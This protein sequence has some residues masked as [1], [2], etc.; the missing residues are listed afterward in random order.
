LPSRE[1]PAVIGVSGSA[2]NKKD[3]SNK[4]KKDDNNSAMSLSEQEVREKLEGMR[5]L[6]KR[7]VEKK[8]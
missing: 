8:S 3:R 7:A 4:V 1:E 5:I 2:P 6:F